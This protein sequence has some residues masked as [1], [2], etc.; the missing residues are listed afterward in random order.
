MSTLGTEITEAL[1]GVLGEGPFPLHEPTFEG[2]ERTFVDETIQSTFVSSVGAFVD[3]FEL[4]LA[5]STGANFAV[6]TVNGTSALHL[7]LLLAGVSPDD[8]VLIPT[9]SFVATANAVRYCQAVPHFVDSCVET[10]GLEPES[11]HMWLKSIAIIKNGVTHNRLTGRPIRAIV[12]MHTF[13]HP[14]RIDRIISI[15]NEFNL[16]VVED[17][18]ESVGSTFQGVHTGTFGTL[19]AL[20]FNGNKI[21]TTGGGGAIL[22]DDPVIA[23][24]AKYLSTTAKNRHLWEFR[25]DE[26]GYNFR[27]PNLNAALGCAQIEQLPVFISR[28]RELYNLYAAAFE[29]VNGCELFEE[30]NGS[31]SNYWLQVLLLDK[32]TKIFRNSILE[33]TN[34]AG[35]QTRPAWNLLHTQKPFEGSP[36][37]PLLNAIDLEQRILCIPSSANLP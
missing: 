36:Q 20:S 13:G 9:L 23:Q 14:C 18:A 24:R 4:A 15:A 25:H 27:M 11:L 3:R 29:D 32:S 17:A 16:V 31:R 6:C 22:T 33:S 35:F 28:K 37:A 7:S 34:N 19:G 21:I 5:K 26:V 30:P 10:L 2:N 1:K 8:E 12:P